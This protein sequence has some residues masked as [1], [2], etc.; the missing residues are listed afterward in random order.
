MTLC[1]LSIEGGARL[2]MIAPDNTTLDYI[3]G[4]SYAPTMDN[5]DAAIQYWQTL[6]SDKNAVFDREVTLDAGDISPTVSWG[7]TPE[8]SIPIDAKIPNPDELPAAQAEPIRTALEYMG[9]EAGQAL[10]GTEIDQIFLGSCTNAR[11]EDIRA[12][13]A[14]IDGHRAKVP[15]LVSPG[16]TAIKQQAE[17]EGLDQIFSWKA[18]RINHES[19]LPW[20]SRAW[21]PNPPDVPGDGSRRG[22][23][24]QDR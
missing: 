15:G 5:R 24:W 9:L 23:P 13:A 22:H 4:R 21:C 8:Q 3:N 19:Q 18:L 14:I 16:S 11:I 20:T 6:N 10:E 7:I 1:N 17:Q 2:G 12:A